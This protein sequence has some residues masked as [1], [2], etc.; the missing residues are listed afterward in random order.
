M[1][2]TLHGIEVGKRALL[3]SQANVSTIG[4][5]ISNVNT[6]GYSR[7]QVNVSSANALNIR[8]NG[9]VSQLGSGVLVDSITRVRDQ[10]LDQLVRE[11]TS[12]N[13]DW[14][15]RKQTMERLEAAINEPSETGLSAVMN[16]FWSAWEDLANDPDSLAARVVVKERAQAFVDT[17]K[18]MD[19]S[20]TS[21]KNELQNQ[22]EYDA[23][24]KQATKMDEANE[25]IEQI[26]KLNESILRSGKQS[27]DLL[28]KRDALVEKLSKLANVN[29]VEQNDGTYT[30]S[31]TDGTNL[32]KGKEFSTIDK[33]SA[34][35]SGELAG[36][37]QSMDIVDQYQTKLNDLVKGLI[38]GEI[39][40][41]IPAGSTLT[42]YGSE[43]I[44]ETGVFELEELKKVQVNGINGLSQLGWS[45]SEDKAGVALFAG[46]EDSSDFSIGDLE[47]NQKIIDNPGLIAA[48]LRTESVNGQNKVVLGNSDLA[49]LISNLRNEEVTIGGN[50]Q[51][52]SDFYQSLISELGT[53]SKVAMNHL[54]NQEAALLATENRRQSVMG[55]SLDEE[56]ANL[57]KYQYAYNAAARMITT[58]DELLDTL[59]NQMAR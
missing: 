42:P 36:I 47:V 15:V 10:F 20:M 5:N 6:E 29:V 34:V 3:A 52:V 9:N 44:G 8:T 23:D 59:I 57:I 27:N 58:T 40:V 35:T 50:S 37:R 26:A 14:S 56:M 28:D 11:Q 19:Q 25:Y 4:H 45:I 51:T 2:S 38:F 41:D 22:L 49:R 39:T 13:G 7:Q 54:A 55:V 48:S 30:V 31:L 24:T 32:V 33:N 53:E 1:V 16:E 17:V 46:V 12:M 18:A 43:L 21:I